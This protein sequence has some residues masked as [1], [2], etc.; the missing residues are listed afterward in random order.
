MCGAGAGGV[1][2]GHGGRLPARAAGDDHRRPHHRRRAPLPAAGVRLSPEPIARGK[3]AFTRR[4]NQFVSLGFGGRLVRIAR[5]RGHQQTRLPGG[6]LA[7]L[8]MVRG[9][10]GS[11]RRQSGW[12]RRWRWRRW[13]RR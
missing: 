9:V 8:T 1:Q 11:R 12:R 5:R 3:R 4:R 13:R 6:E 10:C 2:H 7:L